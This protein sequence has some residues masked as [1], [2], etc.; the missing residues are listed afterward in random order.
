MASLAR[1]TLVFYGTILDQT[2]AFSRRA[3]CYEPIPR[4]AKATRRGAPGQ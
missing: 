4:F 3:N 1:I 2:D